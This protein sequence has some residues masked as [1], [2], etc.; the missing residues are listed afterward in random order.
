MK[1]KLIVNACDCGECRNFG[2]YEN[3]FTNKHYVHIQV[4]GG[5]GYKHIPR[6][7][8]NLLLENKEISG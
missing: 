3:S 7:I 1:H 4:D 2:Y 5:F 8:L 6:E